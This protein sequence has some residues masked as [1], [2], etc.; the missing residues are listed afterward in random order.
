[1]E[2]KLIKIE[3]QEDGEDEAE[4]EDEVG[5]DADAEEEE[6]QQEQPP[7]RK[8]TKNVKGQMRE[9]VFLKSVNSVD[10]LD[11]FRFKVI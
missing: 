8:V 3:Y 5:D 9:Y 6:Q 1:M 11:S 7:S 10:E 4:K 2:E